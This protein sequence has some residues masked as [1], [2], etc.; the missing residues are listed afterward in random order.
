[1]L[2]VH[3][4]SVTVSHMLALF[5]YA[6]KKPELHSKMMNL[7]TNLTMREKRSRTSTI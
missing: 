1:M 2:H 6:T 4:Q 5:F 3:A 7:D